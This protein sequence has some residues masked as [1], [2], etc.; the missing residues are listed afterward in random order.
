MRNRRLSRQPIAEVEGISLIKH[1]LFR[2][3]LSRAANTFHLR[4]LQRQGMNETRTAWLPIAKISGN[5]SDWLLARGRAI[6]YAQL[7]TEGDCI[8][9]DDEI[10]PDLYPTPYCYICQSHSIECLPGQKS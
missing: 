9:W 8:D 2:M 3:V 7:T 6:A 1:E 10:N 4:L 5:D